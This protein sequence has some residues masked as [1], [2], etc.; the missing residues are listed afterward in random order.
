MLQCNFIMLKCNACNLIMLIQFIVSFLGLQVA[1]SGSGALYI[2]SRKD[3]VSQ[4]SVVDK[5]NGRVVRTLDTSQADN[6]SIWNIFAHENVLLLVELRSGQ[7]KCV[8]VYKNE[9]YTS[10][11]LQLLIKDSYFLSRV[12]CGRDYFL[13][14]TL[15]IDKTTLAIVDLNQSG[16]QAKFKSIQLGQMDCIFSLVW[17]ARGDEE[18]GEGYLFASGHEGDAFNSQVYELNVKS[19]VDGAL[20]TPLQIPFMNSY[21]SRNVFFECAMGTDAI[22]CRELCGKKKWEYKN[23]EYPMNILKLE[24]IIHR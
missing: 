19:V 5:Q 17:I 24:K 6:Y 14:S 16:S 18:S 22:L 7:F 12:L 3:G 2:S 23:R 15:A 9:V 10:Y 20:L 8:H 1:L 11:T 13:R 21:G 4:L